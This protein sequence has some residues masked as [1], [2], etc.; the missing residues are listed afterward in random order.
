[1][2]S[3]GFGLWAGVIIKKGDTLRDKTVLEMAC[4]AA[5]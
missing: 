5:K 1:M 2:A 4:V 3:S